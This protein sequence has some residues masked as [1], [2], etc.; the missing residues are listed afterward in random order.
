MTK[1]DL[2]TAVETIYALCA[3]KARNAKDLDEVIE[4]WTV[5]VRVSEMAIEATE[6]LQIAQDYLREA[7]ERLENAQEEKRVETEVPPEVW[8]GIF[9]KL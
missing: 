6:G 9:P 7:K 4:T 3:I 1:G 2:I 5:A 8:D